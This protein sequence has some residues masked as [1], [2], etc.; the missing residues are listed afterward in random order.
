MTNERSPFAP[1]TSYDQSQQL[2]LRNVPRRL[3]RVGR[4]LQHGYDA[5]ILIIN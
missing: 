2:E 1:I 5:Y 4:Q 3:Q